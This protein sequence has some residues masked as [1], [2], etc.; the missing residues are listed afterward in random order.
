MLPLSEVEICDAPVLFLTSTPGHCLFR[1]DP[2][3]TIFILLLF[4]LIQIYDPSPFY[5]KNS[6]V[7]LSDEIFEDINMLIDN[8]GS[9]DR[10]IGLKSCLCYLLA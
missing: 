3:I 2:Q 7:G 9:G 8:E 5:S 4:P 1:A 6:M 10:G